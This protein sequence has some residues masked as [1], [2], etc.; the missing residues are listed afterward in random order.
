VPVGPAA[1]ISGRYKLLLGRQAGA[2]WDGSLF[3]NS[4]SPA[5]NPHGE[6]LDCGATGCLFDVGEDDAGEHT[7]LAAQLPDVTAALRARLALLSK[8]FYTNSETAFRCAHNASLSLEKECACD[9]AAKV[10]GGFFCAGWA[11]PLG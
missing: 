9:R 5:N 11:V 10:C 6:E 4:S 8:S 7:D 1:L 2:G 3:P